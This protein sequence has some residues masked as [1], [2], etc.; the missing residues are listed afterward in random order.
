MN[1][2]L[3]IHTNASDGMWS[4]E[5]LI[6]EVKSNNIGLFSVTDHDSISNIAKVRQLSELNNLNFIPGVEVNCKFGQKVIHILGYNIDIHNKPLLETLE[7]NR[8]KLFELNINQAKNLI[9]QGMDFTIED[10]LDFRKNQKKGHP[11][12]IYY[13][14]K[15]LGAFK[16]FE[17]ALQ[18]IAKNIDWAMQNNP[19][20]EKVIELIH[21]AGGYAILAH[22]GSTLF[23][24][25]L[26]IDEINQLINYAIDGLECFSNYHNV[27]DTK[28]FLNICNKHDLL[29][30]AGSD[31]HGPLFTTRPLG[32][33]KV[34]LKNLRLNGIWKY[35][36]PSI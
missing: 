11:S 4:A 23:G 10:Y 33:P 17:E 1:V 2:D 8:K 25:K 29:I 9:A 30:T 36:K 19:P 6:E 27:N 14:Y 12:V 28:C 24:H 5:E 21:N 18:K 3:H 20:P 15:E 34:E 32:T 26:S 16:T 31:C 13:V 22:P 35:S 7:Y